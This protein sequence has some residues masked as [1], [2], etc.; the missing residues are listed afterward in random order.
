MVV[1][2]KKNKGVRICIDMR[3][4]NEAIQRIKHPMPTMD[5]LIADLNG[6]TVFSKLDLSNAYHQLELGESSW[7]ITIFA[8]HAGLFRYK[9][10]LFGINAA[11]ELFQKAISDLLRGIPGV[12]NLSDDMIIHGRDQISHEVYTG[13][14]TECWSQAEQRKCL[15][16]V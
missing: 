12:K 6:S 11:S 9:R 4:A 14:S 2:P 16:S 10:L 15:F 3:K 7:H 1:V 13:T 5:D 8:I